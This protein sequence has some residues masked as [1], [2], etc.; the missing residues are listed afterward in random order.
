MRIFS[1]DL[2]MKKI[3]M[4]CDPYVLHFTLVGERSD[5]MRQNL[6]ANVPPADV[7]R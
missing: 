1:R 4:C 7:V 3:H 6:V 2:A 5:Q